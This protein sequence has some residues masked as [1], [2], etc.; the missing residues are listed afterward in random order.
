MHGPLNVKTNNF[1]SA[2][3]FYSV[4]VAE[5]WR[6]LSSVTYVAK[7]CTREISFVRIFP[8]PLHSYDR[9][10]LYS[11]YIS[12][13]LIFDICG[14]VHHHSI[15]TT[16]NVMQLGAIVFIIPWEALYMFRV[17][18]TPIIMSVLKLYVQLLVQSYIGMVSDPFGWKMIG[19]RERTALRHDQISLFRQAINLERP[20]LQL[21]Y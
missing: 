12:L 20:H 8:F 7:T 15:N 1:T 18:F 16:S 11:E 9:S 14:S 5:R 13:F 3:C 4:F 19:S 2:T 6:D 17:L 21:S 10:Y